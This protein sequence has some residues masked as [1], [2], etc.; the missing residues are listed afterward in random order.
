MAT[1]TKQQ[2][3][4][5]EAAKTR[6]AQG[7]ANDQDIRN[8]QYAQQQHG[9]NAGIAKVTSALG[10]PPQSEAEMSVANDIANGTFRFP[11]VNAVNPTQADATAMQQPLQQAGQQV[12]DYSQPNVFTSFLKGALAM[13]TKPQN[14]Q[15]GQS[16]LFQKAGLGNTMASLQ[17]SLNT[18]SQQLGNNIKNLTA[19]LESSRGIYT[20]QYTKAAN[21]YTMIKNEY[22]A[23]VKR[24]QELDD[25]EKAQQWEL[26]ILNKQEAHQ[27]EM[28]KLQSTY[29]PQVIGT[30]ENGNSIYGSW[31]VST[32]QY[33]AVS[34]NNPTNAE[35]YI[36]PSL[37]SNF[38]SWVNA[39]GTPSVQFGGQTKFEQFHPGFDIGAPKGTPVQPYASGDVV[40][41]GTSKSF[42]NF[43]K[44]QDAEGNIWQYSH[45]DKIN[46]KKGD[47]VQGSEGVQSVN[48]IGTVGNTGQT[49][50]VSG[51]DGSHLDL[52]IIRPQ[53]AEQ[54]NLQYGGLTKAQYTVVSP[55]ATA[56]RNEQ[57]VKD[58]NVAQN[59]NIFMNSIASDTTNPADDIG[60][61]YAFAKIMD[62]NSVVREGEYATV[63]K[64]AQSWADSFGFNAKRVFSN[65]KF[66]STEAIANM[67]K[68]A[69]LKYESMKKPYSQ[70]FDEYAR[71]IEIASGLS[72]CE[73]S[74][75]LTQYA[76]E[77]EV[78]QP[79]QQNNN[80]P[81]GI[82]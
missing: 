72:D 70:I 2:L 25:A 63:Q 54:K 4:G 80:D 50:S 13:K 23:T 41:I 21:N 52:R 3:E 51:S 73:G 40:E 36:N 31:N 26:D 42:G 60:I 57:N 16:A 58:F 71:R 59:G 19:M 49:Y 1:L 79:G 62:P 14:E 46:V 8:L 76:I 75:F 11:N 38:D 20:D 7:T 12:L 47:S 61:I 39:T 30:D 48:S 66:L 64:Y 43:V 18:R 45:L 5:L 82:L 77:P 37:L 9:Y 65:T 81:L 10:H 27:K 29:N 6:Y 74:K 22:D 67:K 34:I 68:T 28:L 33:D 17:E 32:N 24:L 55:I 56:F 15:L 53:E 35:D 78:N 69:Q 44:I